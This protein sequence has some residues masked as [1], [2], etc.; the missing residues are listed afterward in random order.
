[1][2]ALRVLAASLPD[3]VFHFT[4]GDINGDNPQHEGNLSRVSWV[5]YDRDLILYDAV[6]H[7]GGAGI[8]WHCLQKKI[9]TLVYPVDFD[10][11]DHAARLAYHNKGIWIRGGISELEK[12]A[13]LLEKIVER[14]DER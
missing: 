4:E 7:H 9:P 8:M 2:K 1:M 14:P 10:Q 13:P 11:L 12:V 5:D 6:I 3:W